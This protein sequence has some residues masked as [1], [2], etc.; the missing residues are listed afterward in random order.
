MAGGGDK[1]EKATPKR[2]EESR[3][4]GQMARSQ[5]LN[6]ALVLIGGLIAVAVWG[7]HMMDKLGESMRST[8]ALMGNPRGVDATMLGQLFVDGGKTI[9]LTV[10]PVAMACMAAGVFANVIQNRPRLNA[11]GLKPDAKK[12]NP[13]T[14]A[15]NLF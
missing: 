9:A 13:L 6:G 7:P 11:A 4:K 14:G 5:D 8:I 1:T 10:G 2:R 15:K 3:K 12:I